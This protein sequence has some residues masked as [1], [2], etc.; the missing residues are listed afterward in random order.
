MR[1]YH[2]PGDV[3]SLINVAGIGIVEGTDNSAE[4]E[5][6]TEFVLS[7][8]Q[9]RYF[10]D[11]VKEYPLVEGIAADPEVTPLAEI[12]QPDVQLGE[13][14]DLEGTLDLLQKSGAL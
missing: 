8:E 7:D 4:A 11:V 6:F 12:Q 14:D 10:A 13:L 2:P 3:G 1:G 5:Q 9:Q